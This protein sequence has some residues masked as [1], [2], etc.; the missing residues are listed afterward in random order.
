MCTLTVIARRAG[1]YRLVM[2][3]DELRT[4]VAG[5][6]PRADSVGGRRFVA[7]RDAQAGG[8]WIASDE[9]GRTLCLL[10]GD[11][12]APDWRES[13]DLRSR[14]ELLLE[15]VAQPDRD[16][17]EG[18]LL[19]RLAAGALRVRPFQLIAVERDGVAITRWRFD[20]RALVVDSA[21]PPWIATS[22]GFDPLG[23]AQARAE[24]FRRWWSNFA[25]GEPSQDDQLELHRTHVGAPNDSA[26][27]SFCLHR[28]ELGSVSLTS[29]EVSGTDVKMRY[30]PG[31]P[32]QRAALHGVLLRCN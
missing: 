7:P 24:Q 23:V 10:N 18:E 16:A 3:R 25:P 1:G 29:V 19:R 20:G 8:S 4:R 27:A 32:C 17:L 11:A 31:A 12:I 5:Q 14:G 30:E 2:T 22:N 6:P 21:R 15:L 26:L 13:M 28:P 9:A